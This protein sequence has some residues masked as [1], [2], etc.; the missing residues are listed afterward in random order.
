MSVV[1]ASMTGQ[2]PLASNDET[3][4]TALGK[5]LGSRDVQVQFEHDRVLI[6]TPGGSARKSGLAWASVRECHPSAMA[7]R[8]I[9]R[10]SPGAPVHGAPHSA[11]AK[12]SP[13]FAHDKH[14]KPVV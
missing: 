4:L 11:L 13:C 10:T 2:L 8:V 3:A 12:K 9:R 6:V 5:S 14:Q 1:A 7:Q